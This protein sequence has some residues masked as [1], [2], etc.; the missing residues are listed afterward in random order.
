MKRKSVIS[1]PQL[2]MISIGSALMFPYTIMPV[3]HSANANQDVWLV[4]ILGVFYVVFLSIP[5]LFLANRFRGVHIVEIC[6]LI[7]GKSFG[8]IYVALFV[9]IFF[10]CFCSCLAIGNVFI[11]LDLLTET[12]K[13]IIYAFSIL[14]MAYLV[15]KGPGTIGRISLFVTTFIIIT[16]ILFAILGVSMMD[17]KILRPVMSDSTFWNLN[18]AAFLHGSR[19]SEIL[20]FLMFSYYADKKTNI[21]RSYLLSALIYLSATSLIILP[22]ITVLGLDVAKNAFN[23]YFSYT[24]QVHGYD[25]IQRVQAINALAWFPG[26]IFKLSLNIFLGCHILSG[27]FKTKSHKPFILPFCIAGFVTVMLPGL[28]KVNTLLELASDSVFP[29]IVLPFTV[30]LPLIMVLVYLLRKKK[31]DKVLAKKKA[32][33]SVLDSEE[34]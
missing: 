31:I 29:W 20:D 19:I 12:P 33:A 26:L 28:N 11:N 18:K 15:Y 10:F 7:F 5:A 30:G 4:Q 9:P 13:W 17:L 1:E 32:R 21:N 22:T 27:V 34:I 24:R 6:K 14:P 25:V 16:I 3:L 8:K 23:P 2:I